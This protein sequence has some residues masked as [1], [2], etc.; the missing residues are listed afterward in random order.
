MSPTSSP[1]PAEG[2]ADSNSKNEE[3]EPSEPDQG[4]PTKKLKC[5]PS[6]NLNVGFPHFPTAK[7]LYERLLDLTKAGGGGE[8]V[9]RNFVGVIRDISVESS[10]VETDLFP[11]GALEYY[12]KKNMGYDYTQDEYDQWQLAERGGEQGD[13]RVGVSAS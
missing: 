9:V 7:E 11:R 1:G 5:A 2:E 3:Q 6:N 8:F 10:V 12:T 13:Y 4:S